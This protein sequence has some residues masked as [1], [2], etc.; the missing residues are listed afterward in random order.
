LPGSKRR[1]SPGGLRAGAVRATHGGGA[2][3]DRGMAA[4]KRRRASPAIRPAARSNSRGSNM[5][6]WPGFP[7]IKEKAP[8]TAGPVRR[9]DARHTRGALPAYPGRPARSIGEL[10]NKLRIDPRPAPISPGWGLDRVKPTARTADSLVVPGQPSAPSRR[11]GGYSDSLESRPL[12]VI[13]AMMAGTDTLY[14]MGRSGSMRR[15]GPR[16][17]RRSQNISR[18]RKFKKRAARIRAHPH[19][20]RNQQILVLIRLHKKLAGI[21]GKHQS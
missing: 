10:V 11:L 12:G 8:H 15:I 13:G 6:K 7:C 21:D 5:A 2:Q 4:G 17:T 3:D 20:R 9:L 14:G 18:K 19:Q 16:T 1:R